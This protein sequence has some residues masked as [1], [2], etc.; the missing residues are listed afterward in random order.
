MNPIN[1]PGFRFMDGMAATAGGVP[2]RMSVRDCGPVWT[3]DTPGAFSSMPGMSINPADP[4][5]GGCLAVLLGAD[6]RYIHPAIPTAGARGM[7]WADDLTRG[8]YPTLGEACVAVAVALGRW[9]G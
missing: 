3:P 4:A 8:F 5:T 7:L 1:L 6:V 2:G 9:P